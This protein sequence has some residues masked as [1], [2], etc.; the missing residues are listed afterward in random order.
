VETA[1][2]SLT[3]LLIETISESADETVIVSAVPTSQSLPASPQPTVSESADQPITN[4][5]FVG[6]EVGSSKRRD[7]A[8]RDKG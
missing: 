8:D 6:I 7:A 4:S 5:P 1:A 2:A 3:V